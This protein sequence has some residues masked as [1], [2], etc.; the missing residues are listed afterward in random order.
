VLTFQRAD[1]RVIGAEIGALWFAAIQ[2]IERKKNLAGSAPTG[3]FVPAEAIERVVGQIGEA[4]KQRARSAERS[5]ARSTAFGPEL[6]RVSVPSVR[7]RL[8]LRSHS[9]AATITTAV[10]PFRVTVCGPGDSAKSMTS[11]NFAFTCAT[12]QVPHQ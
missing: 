12:V 3:S 8:V 7:P 5:T 9:F 1:R 6:G 4:Q 11:L 10:R 2:G